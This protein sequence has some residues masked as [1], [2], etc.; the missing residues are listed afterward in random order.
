L[1]LGVGV[2]PI[3]DLERFVAGRI[4]FFVLSTRYFFA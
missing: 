4:E 1:W 3:R 2:V